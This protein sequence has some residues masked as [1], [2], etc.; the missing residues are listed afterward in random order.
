MGATERFLRLAIIWLRRSAGLML[1][2][3]GLAFWVRLVGV[4]PQQGWRFDTMQVEWRIVVPALAVLCPVAGLGLWLVVSWGTV[5]WVLVAAL[6]AVM[7][8][9]LPG[10]FGKADLQLLLHFTGLV[11]LGGLKLALWHVTR[12]PRRALSPG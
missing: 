12:K 5:V 8:L 7:H 9:A 2:A 1:F 4:Y 6:E 3:C 11:T 10:L